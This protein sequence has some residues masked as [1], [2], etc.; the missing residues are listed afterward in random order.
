MPSTTTDRLNGLTTSIAIKAPCVV[1]TSATITLSGLQTVNGVA[2]V[3][4]DRV[5]VKDQTDS[6]QNGIY[7]AN[8]STWARATDFDGHR[9]VV[10]GTLVP[11]Y[12]SAGSEEIYRVTT[13]NP[14]SIGS[15][16]ITFEESVFVA[17]D[18]NA[19]T[20]LQ[21]GS[22]ATSRSVRDKLRDWVSAMDFMT[23]AQAADV[24]AGTLLLDVTTACQ[25]A[26]DTGK[27][28]YFPA[29]SYHVTGLTWSTIGQ[30]FY[31]DGPEKSIIK[32]YGASAKCF[33]SIGALVRCHFHDLY[34]Q[35]DAGTGTGIDLSSGLLY[36]STFRNIWL[37]TAGKCIYAPDEF[38]STFEHV[39]FASTGDNG[40]EIEGGNTTTMIGC[41]A[42]TFAAGAYPYRLYSGAVMISC[43]GIDSAA[44]DY[45][46]LAGRS[47]AK[48]DPD[49]YQYYLHCINCNFE[50][51]HKNGVQLR[52]N[53]LAVFDS[54]SFLAAAT[55]AYDA[56]LYI[57][58]N[59][60]G[61]T[62]RNCSF[63]SKGAARSKLAEIYS[64]TGNP[65]IVFGITPITWD[66]A[67]VLTTIGAITT[68]QSAFARYAISINELLV[69]GRL[70][71]TGASVLDRVTPT[72]TTPVVID[73]SLGNLFDITATN[74]TPFTIGN[75]TTPVEGQVIA[76]TVRNASG[77]A[78][79]GVTF[80]TAY[81][82][83]AWTSPADTFSRSIVFKYNGTNWVEQSRTPADVPN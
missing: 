5:L 36:T 27:A 32:V 48:G 60:R 17:G 30:R 57:E 56:C 8:S 11:T 77:G 68:A 26:I 18:S 16:A 81:K 21:L 9:D 41:Y 38:N 28:V 58:H 46:L 82:L 15:S 66:A 2:V 61:V 35:G 19:V 64:E 20:F 69:T 54:C 52:F 53:G 25:N 22:G 50:D 62:L 49:N 1:A 33:T 6:R 65:P 10:R 59:D 3:D 63:A 39:Q 40:I 14:I 42:H 76:I 73:A 45:I 83:A 67:G 7:V 43:N 72:Y 13:A 4:G 55:G 37:A 75:P 34:I 51:F 80:D 74:A 31:G 23:S 78:L 29:G 24:K 12:T 79:G 47:V 44:G 71:V 70:K